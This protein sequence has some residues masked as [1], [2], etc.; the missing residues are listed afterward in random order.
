MGLLDKAMER[1]LKKQME[2]MTGTSDLETSG[3][4][5]PTDSETVSRL[6]ETAE[7]LVDAFAEVAAN[8]LMPGMAQQGP[9]LEFMLK[10][11][12]MDKTDEEVFAVIHDI[13]AKLGHV[14]YPLGVEITPI[15]AVA[16]TVV[17][18]ESE[19]IFNDGNDLTQPPADVKPV[20]EEN[21]D[22]DVI[23][24]TDDY[25]PFASE[26]VDDIPTHDY[27]VAETPGEITEVE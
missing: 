7:R 22:N 18:D 17:T 20:I 23:D 12:L 3:I 8:D 5:S 2:R 10:T 14:L 13:F 9:M 6:S 26:S 15:T 16:L 4:S 21:D 25:N 1:T 27:P 24:V 19:L 11:Q